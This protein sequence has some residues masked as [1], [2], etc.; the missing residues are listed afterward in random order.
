MSFEVFISCFKDGQPAGVPCQQVRNAFGSFI[1]QSGA[2][3]WQ[4]SYDETNSCDIILT[5]HNDERLLHG[6]TVV[7]PC[8]DERFWDALASILRLGDIVLYF[9][10]SCPPLVS[11]GAV[12][13]H[14]PPDMIKAMGEPK[15]VATGRQILEALHSA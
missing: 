8:S 2:F 1:T 7:R 5:P 14:L 13:R 3:E 12:I 15:C 10:G 4:L 6:F 9:P 11:D